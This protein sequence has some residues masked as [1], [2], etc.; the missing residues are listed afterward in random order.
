MLQIVRGYG[1]YLVLYLV[2]GRFGYGFVTSE[3]E[4]YALCTSGVDRYARYVYSLPMMTQQLRAEIRPL[5]IDGNGRVTCN[6]IRC[7][8]QTAVSNSMRYDLNDAE[9]LQI[10]PEVAEMMGEDVPC[11]ENCGAQLER[12][13]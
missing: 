3:Q 5:W 10:T 13:A 6:K 2:K 9:L 11:C 1:P 8:G 12:T 7:A 4:A